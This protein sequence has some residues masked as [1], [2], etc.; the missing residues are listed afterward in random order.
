[1]EIFTSTGCAVVQPRQ[2]FTFAN[3]QEVSS[4][5]LKETQAGE[6]TESLEE[7]SKGATSLNSTPVGGV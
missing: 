4:S 6:A 2:F 1:M 5:K 3:K 7:N